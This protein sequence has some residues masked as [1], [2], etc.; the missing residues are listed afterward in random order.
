M[1]ER[2]QVLRCCSCRTFQVKR[3][4]RW[5]C[6]VCGER[7]AL[8]RDH[9]RGCAA[10]CRRHVQK[11]NR[12][13]G[14]AEQAA[15]A[16]ARCVEESV[17]DKKYTAVEPEGSSG[18]QEQKVEVRPFVSRWNKYLDKGGEDVEEEEELHPNRPQLRSHQDCVQE[19]RKHSSSFHSS[20]A[21]EENRACGLTYQAKKVKAFESRKTSVAVT[22]QG[23]EDVLCDGIV[24]PVPSRPLV[25]EAA[26]SSVRS[27]HITASKWKTF[28]S[29]AGNYIEDKDEATLT[30]QKLEPLKATA[31]DFPT[32]GGYAQWEEE[33]LSP[34]AGAQIRNCFTNNTCTAQQRA[35]KP[36]STTATKHVQTAF[37]VSSDAA[38]DM[39]CGKC[40][41]HLMGAG[42]A[43]AERNKER[44]CM[45]DGTLMPAS[46]LSKACVAPSA[47]SFVS[48]NV[49]SN[50]L[51]T[52]HH[53]LFCTGDDFD[54]DL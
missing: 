11:L 7:Q 44:L 24:V 3:S 2:F 28:L 8:L 29:S 46:R 53:G 22:E 10:D 4:R 51:T 25:S 19:Q 52:P 5:S 42:S 35:S 23:H 18:W 36:H 12:L 13:R 38:G 45:V 43:V 50:P 39:T 9:G 49:V 34:D 47:G 17:D 14:E 41:D 21:Q 27:C 1:A 16:P 15:R 26:S 32:S 20:D 48:C 30:A 37:N 40:E 6:A 33:S 31:A 54:D